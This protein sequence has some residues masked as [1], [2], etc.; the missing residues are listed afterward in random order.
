MCPPGYTS[1]YN[2]Y[3]TMQF[4]TVQAEFQP[5]NMSTNNA[6]DPTVVTHAVSLS[7]VIQCCVVFSVCMLVVCVGRSCISRCCKERGE[8]QTLSNFR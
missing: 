2:A 5:L 3:Q 4:C 7:G 1:A 6:T 8:F